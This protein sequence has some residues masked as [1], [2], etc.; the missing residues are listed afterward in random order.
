M[1]PVHF[2]VMLAVNLAIGANT[3]PVGVDLLA[4]CR[5]G[6]ISL[7]D[8]SRYVIFFIGAMVIALFFIVL[9]P[10]MVV[11]IPNYFMS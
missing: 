4:A 11:F 8:A 9:F 7:E 10:P 2:G 3:P 1:D 5:I 6:E